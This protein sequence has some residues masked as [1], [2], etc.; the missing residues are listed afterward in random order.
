MPLLKEDLQ[1]E[2]G[3]M[4]YLLTI[5]Y[6]IDELISEHYPLYNLEFVQKNDSYYKN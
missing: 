3:K 1:N 6:N 2:N 5:I 4:F